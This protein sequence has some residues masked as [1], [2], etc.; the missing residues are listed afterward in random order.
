MGQQ[1][2]LLIVLGTIIIG[3]AIVVGINLFQ[4]SAVEHKRDLLINEG[5]TVAN[6]AYQY[7]HRPRSLGGGQFSFANYEIPPTMINSGNGRFTST[8]SNTQVIIIGTGNELVSGSDSV[9]VQF[10]VTATGISTLVIN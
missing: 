5:M 7:Y 2:L 3:I 6:N 10:T 4:A 9:K 8:S 1:Q